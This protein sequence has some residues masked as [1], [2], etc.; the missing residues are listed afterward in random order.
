MSI[1]T[2]AAIINAVEFLQDYPTPITDALYPI[3][4]RFNHPYPTIGIGVLQGFAKSRPL[5]KR[6]GQSIAIA[7]PK[8]NVQVVEP[9]PIKLNQF[10]SQKE[11]NDMLMVREDAK[12]YILNNAMQELK[13]NTKATT[14]SLAIQSLTGKISHAIKSEGGASDVYTVEFGTIANI[15]SSLWNSSTK[16][17]DVLKLLNTM[18]NQVAQAGYG[19]GMEFFV[20]ED[21]FAFIFNL[22]VSI[23]NDTR[24]NARVEGNS[25]QL[26]AYT[27]TQF[28]YTYTN[29]SNSTQ[30][31]AVPQGTIIGRGT[32]YPWKMGYMAIDVEGA[33]ATAFFV[34]PIPVKDPNGTK[35]VSYSTPLPIPI[36]GAMRSA[37]VL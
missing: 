23:A 32:T 16:L 25:I 24:I 12:N 14:E 31:P 4:A 7:D 27:I 18:S 10:I 26:G 35:L 17:G 8:T 1:I 13:N 37:K 9:Q 28:P 5:V 20:A 3:S 36:V 6:N 29:P 11:A 33:G 21:V 22:A 19:M 2:A 30:V 34:E 15:S